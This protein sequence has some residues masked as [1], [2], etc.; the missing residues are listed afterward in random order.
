MPVKRYLRISAL[1]IAAI[2]SFGISSLATAYDFGTTPEALLKEIEQVGAVLVPGQMSHEEMQKNLKGIGCYLK[3]QLW[4]NPSAVSDDPF[5]ARL[6][7]FN[8]GAGVKKYSSATEEA[9]ADEK[10]CFGPF[11]VSWSTE[12]VIISLGDGPAQLQPGDA[13]KALEQKYGVPVIKDESNNPRWWVFAAGNF[14]VKLMPSSRGIL[15]YEV[16]ILSAAVYQQYVA[17]RKAEEEAMRQDQLLKAAAAEKAKTYKGRVLGV[18]NPGEQDGYLVEAVFNLKGC[19]VDNNGLIKGP[20]VALPG[21]PT[22]QLSWD[23]NPTEPGARLLLTYSI[24]KADTK[25]QFSYVSKAFEEM[26]ERLKSGFRRLNPIRMGT[27]TWHAYGDESMAVAITDGFINDVSARE[28]GVLFMSRKAYNLILEEN[29]KQEE[30]IK[31]QQN[32]K[33]DNLKKL[34]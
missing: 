25:G 33:Q 13:Y 1:T 6:G 12:T 3:P 18:F 20:C 8:K 24:P 26:S 15:N 5:N 23:D 34:F 27:L 32:Q 19:S 10:S 11:H 21:N 7:F 17:Q 2:A 4:S 14:A 9:R 28:A 16:Q 31:N 22:A 30:A 29:R